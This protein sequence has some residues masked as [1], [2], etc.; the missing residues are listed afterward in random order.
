MAKF[1]MAGTLLGFENIAQTLGGPTKSNV[2]AV[3]SISMDHADQGIS[4]KSPAVC[5]ASSPNVY[6][7]SWMIRRES[8]VNRTYHLIHIL[9]IF[10]FKSW[11]P[12]EISVTQ[13]RGTTNKQY[14]KTPQLVLVGETPTLPEQGC[15]PSRR[16]GFSENHFIAKKGFVETRKYGFPQLDTTHKQ[17][18]ERNAT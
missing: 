8:L 9:S 16:N 14:C 2:T 3:H 13:R 5:G 17:S 18:S 11:P 7:S 1:G 15:L 10:G 4:L 6:G 12:V